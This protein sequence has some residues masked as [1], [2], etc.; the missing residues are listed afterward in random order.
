MTEADDFTP[1][2]IISRRRRPSGV[3]STFECRFSPSMLDVF[4]LPFLVVRQRYVRH[5]CSIEEFAARQ[6]EEDRKCLLRTCLSTCCECVS[7]AKRRAVSH[8]D[9]RA[10]RAFA[11]KN[12]VWFHL[13]APSASTKPP[14]P[15]RSVPMYRGFD[16]LAGNTV[17]ALTRGNSERRRIRGPPGTRRG[18]ICS[19]RLH[20]GPS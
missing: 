10:F 6:D 2:S 5:T 17:V 8:T 13:I 1:T 4:Q 3:F 12:S 11:I 7:T 15:P 9:P 20:S 14:G 19:G 16:R 18:P